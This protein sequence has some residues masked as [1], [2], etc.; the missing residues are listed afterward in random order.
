MSGQIFPPK[1]RLNWE[2]TSLKVSVEADNREIRPC[3]GLIEGNWAV[4]ALVP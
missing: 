1:K 2:K 3:L 4:G